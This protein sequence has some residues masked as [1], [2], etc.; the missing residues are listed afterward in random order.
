MITSKVS[1]ANTAAA[2]AIGGG[3]MLWWL[4][5]HAAGLGALAALTGVLVAIIFHV[6]HYIEKKRHNKVVEKKRK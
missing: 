4:D 1:I 2:G 6:L 3:G 5:Q